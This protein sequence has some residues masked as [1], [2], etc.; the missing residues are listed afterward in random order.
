[1]KP[2]KL[3]PRAKA[4]LFAAGEYYER[5]SWALAGRFAAEMDR[6]VQ[7]ICAAPSVYRVFRAEARRHFGGRFPY[8]VIYVEEPDHILVLAFAHFKRRPGY[9]VDRLLRD[10]G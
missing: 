6:L 9:W 2:F 10:R 5:E 3:H 4:D 1:V 7:E 8:A